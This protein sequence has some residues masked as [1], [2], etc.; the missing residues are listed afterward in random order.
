M[1]FCTFFSNLALPRCEILLCPWRREFSQ[2]LRNA[3]ANYSQKIEASQRLQSATKL[4]TKFNKTWKKGT[5]NISTIT[6]RWLIRFSK[7][8]P[9]RVLKANT[10]YHHFKPWSE[11]IFPSFISSHSFGKNPPWALLHFLPPLEITRREKYFHRLRNKI[12]PM[13]IQGGEKYN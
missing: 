4:M 12:L 13:E 7:H 8:L 6:Q 2:K 3:T 11:I 9:K 5:K 1:I 10:S